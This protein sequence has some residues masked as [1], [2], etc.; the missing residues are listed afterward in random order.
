MKRFRFWFCSQCYSDLFVL[1]FELGKKVFLLS[2]RWFW[3]SLAM[4]GW[5]ED[6]KEEFSFRPLF[7]LTLSY[8]GWMGQYG[9]IFIFFSSFL[10]FILSFYCFRIS[11]LRGSVHMAKSVLRVSTPVFNGEDFFFTWCQYSGL[12]R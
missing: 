7:V 6:K 5:V 9:I 12:H 11:D 2:R 4:D 10:F 1:A 8:Y 3:A